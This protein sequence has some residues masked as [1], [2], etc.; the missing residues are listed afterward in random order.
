MTLKDMI[1]SDKA[2]SKA[3]DESISVKPQE[4]KEMTLKDMI[5]SDKAKEKA[6]H[7]SVIEKLEEL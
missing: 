7:D 1:D 5:A 3:E 4:S 6:A 2:K